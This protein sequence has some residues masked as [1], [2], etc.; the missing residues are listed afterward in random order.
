M[1]SHFGA[2]HSPC[3][4]LFRRRVDCPHHHAAKVV[5][6]DPVCGSHIAVHALPHTARVLGARLEAH[7]DLV[8]VYV[9]DVD[10]ILQD[11]GEVEGETACVVCHN[12]DGVDQ[13]ANLRPELE[14]YVAI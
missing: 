1:A 10:K 12:V 11:L 8:L 9:A 4:V 2:I 5:G 13:V 14:T 7:V 6:L 3:L